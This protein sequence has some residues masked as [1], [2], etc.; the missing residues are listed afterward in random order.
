M[1]INEL[2]AEY[3]DITALIKKVEIAKQKTNGCF[4]VFDL[5]LKHFKNDIVQGFVE[6]YDKIKENTT[7]TLFLIYSTDIASYV[8]YYYAKLELAYKFEVVY[9]SWFLE[10][11]IYAMFVNSTPITEYVYEKSLNKIKQLLN[12][13]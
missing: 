11:D 4:H 5:V 9:D 2:K 1:S 6:N 12:E 8:S 3:E 13:L 7:P 10:K